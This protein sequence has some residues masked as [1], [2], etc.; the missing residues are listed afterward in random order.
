M[1]TPRP[2]YVG[3]DYY[4]RVSIRTIP[5]PSTNIV[6]DDAIFE[7]TGRGA[8]DMSK[9]DAEL[10]V[11]VVNAYDEMLAALKEALAALE[12]PETHDF[13]SFALLQEEIR[14][15]IAKNDTAFKHAREAGVIP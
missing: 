8:G 7:N 5:T 13:L 10:I 1:T 14:V 4:G 6:G 2:W 12:S 9:E 3:K 15:I 11:R